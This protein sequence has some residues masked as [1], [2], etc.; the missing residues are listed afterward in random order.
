MT[1]NEGRHVQHVRGA[2]YSALSALVCAVERYNIAVSGFFPAA[3]CFAA[4]LLLLLLLPAS[5]RWTM[6]QHH[7]ECR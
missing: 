4:V 3:D 6:V 2:W 5:L 7:F 1:L